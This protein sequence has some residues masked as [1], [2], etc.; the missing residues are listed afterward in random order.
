MKVQV[1]MF[2]AAR[3]YTCQEVVQVELDNPACV[4]T[5]KQAL[6]EQFP[7]LEPL[8]GHLLIAVDNDYADDNCPLNENSEI[9]VIPP[10][11]GG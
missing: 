5:L 9:A 6:L 1:K 7:L 4:A 3:Q 11:S 10:V 8:S 2:A